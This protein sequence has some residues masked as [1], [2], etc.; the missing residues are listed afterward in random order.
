MKVNKPGHIEAYRTQ[1]LIRY[2][3]LGTVLSPDFHVSYP[4]VFASEYGIC[5]LPET[6]Q[7]GTVSLY[8]FEDFPLKIGKKWT[9]LEG[10]YS[11]STIHY[12]NGFWWLFATLNGVLELFYSKDVLGPYN[13]YPMGIV[14]RDL[15]CSRSGGSLI[16]HNGNIYRPAQNCSNGYGMNLNLMLVEKMTPDCYKEKLAIQ[17]LFQWKKSSY[18]NRIGGH[19]LSIAEFQGKTIAAIDWYQTDHWMNPPISLLMKL[20]KSNKGSRG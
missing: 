17:N 20:F 3:S 6:S 12:N 13:R 16:V 15:S 7:D 18:P 9:L 14:S 19:H 2:E 5:M 4:Q 11:D 10:R 8:L 1:N